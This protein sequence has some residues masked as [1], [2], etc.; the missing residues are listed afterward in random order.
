MKQFQE[1]RFL[2]KRS[3]RPDERQELVRAIRARLALEPDILFA[4]LHGSFV[5]E[6]SFRD[7]DVGILTGP[8]KGFSFE[9]TLTADLSSALGHEIEVR[10]L[11]R[12]P[13]E[14][15]MAVLQGGQLLFCRDE[16]ARRDFIERVGRRYR[17]YA[18]FRNLF[19]EAA[20][21]EP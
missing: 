15:Q 12:A 7:I 16:A 6:D 21:A 19:L 20:G 10:L 4:Y 8:D 18:H 17:E 14:F 9:S 3:A 5:T 2:P 1:K 13:V 11:H